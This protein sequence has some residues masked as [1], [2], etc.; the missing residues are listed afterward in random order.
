M[1]VAV[2][3]MRARLGVVGL[4]G[5]EDRSVSAAL[6]GGGAASRSGP[7]SVVTRWWSG[8]GQTCR[9]RCL[10]FREQGGQGDSWPPFPRSADASRFS[11]VS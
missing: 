9:V 8:S 7:F 4:G 3:T 5:K 6:G 1:G 10:S 2:G 11:T